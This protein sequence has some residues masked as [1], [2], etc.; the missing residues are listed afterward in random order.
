VSERPNFLVIL[1]D[2]LPAAALG[3]YGHRVVRSPHID[4]LASRGVRFEQA[5]TNCPLCTPAR[6][7]FCAGQ[8]ASGLGVFDNGADF[9]SSVPTFLHHLRRAGYETVLSGKMHFVGADQLHGFERRLTTDIYPSSFAWTPDWRRGVYRNAG[10]SVAAL[11]D[12][13]V[14]V[15]NESLRYDEEVHFRAVEALRE[16][17]LSPRER[18]PFF[19]C[20][21]FTHP[22]QPMTIARKWWDLYSDAEIDSPAAPAVPMERMHPYNQWL[23]VHHSADV[24]PPTEDDV[25]RSRR[26]YYGMIGFLDEKVGQLLDELARLGL[27]DNTMVVFASDHGEML[28][29]H[30]MWFK[31]TY[32][33]ASI[34]IPLLVAGPGVPA[35][36]RV[37]ETVSLVDLFPSILDL[38]GVPQDEWQSEDLDGASFRRLLREPDP[39]WRNSAIVE[40]LGEGTCQPMRAAVRGPLKYVH[41]HEHAPV[42]FDLAADPLESTNRASD[43]AY[44]SRLGQ[45][46]RLA[47]DGYDAAQMRRRVLRSQQDRLRL[48]DALQQGRQESWDVCPHFDPSQQYYR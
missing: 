21:S 2:Q 29:E 1:A 14:C 9:P 26:A 25:R 48:W 10:S 8:L 28:G 32:F 11:R 16:F 24:C 13:G 36:R 41:V 30:G 7:A 4:A 38:A 5:Y 44:A 37:G 47:L 22:H 3:T 31:R 43:P 15:W 35:G 40:Y 34:R 6:A 39:E 46:E 17:R 18:R 33:D 12:S 20:A 19:L 23:Q 42:L 45:M 27:A